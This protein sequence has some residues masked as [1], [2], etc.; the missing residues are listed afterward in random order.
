MYALKK[1]CVRHVQGKNY[2]KLKKKQGLY[3]K[4]VH[5]KNKLKST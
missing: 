5:E 3:E 1:L 4:R 2:K